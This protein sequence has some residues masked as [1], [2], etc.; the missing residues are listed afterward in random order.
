[1]TP[2]EQL[3]QNIYDRLDNDP[4]LATILVLQEKEGVT[5]NDIAQSLATTTAKMTDAGVLKG[6]AILVM[7]PFFD[8]DH[9][10]SVSI[11]LATTTYIS[12]R[13]KPM[14]NRSPLGT[15]I[16]AEQIALN[17]I[18]L[19][20]PYIM[21]DLPSTLT[22]HKGDP[23][24]YNDGTREIVITVKAEIKICRTKACALPQ[25]T[26]D[27]EGNVTITCATAG[28]TI[29]YSANGSYPCP[30][31]GTVYAPFNV[32]NGTQVRAVAFKQPNLAASDLACA[33]INT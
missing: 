17:V 30:A 26:A 32:A 20:H 12:C 6:A 8:V 21:Y 22:S 25:I 11:T 10:A 33:T 27:A 1:M 7:E 31:N 14:V 23:I 24:R 16:T 4:S 13:E 2:L 19:L 29:Y 5:D 28:A 18:R 15:N 3:Q 9:P